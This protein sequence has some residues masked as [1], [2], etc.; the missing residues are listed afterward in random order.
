M[1]QISPLSIAGTAILAATAI[2]AC[3]T[4]SKARSRNDAAVAVVTV[5][6][7][8]LQGSR[9]PP[10]VFETRSTAAAIEANAWAA[11]K[12]RAYGEMFEHGCSSTS[13]CV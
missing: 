2:T 13:G 7:L 3:L 10:T 5:A 1:P 6:T 8:E 9:E 12:R 11:V 4:A